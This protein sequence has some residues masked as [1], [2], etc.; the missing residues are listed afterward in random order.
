VIVS[1]LNGHPW[2][3]FHVKNGTKG[4]AVGDPKEATLFHKLASDLIER[5]QA[6]KRQDAGCHRHA[7]LARPKQL[8]FDVSTLGC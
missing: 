8:G 6:Q 7:P 4:Q 5:A 2:Q 3:R 1:T